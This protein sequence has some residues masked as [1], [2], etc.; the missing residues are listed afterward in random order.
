MMSLR[1]IL[2]RHYLL[3]ALGPLALAGIL[4]GAYF[5]FLSLNSTLDVESLRAGQ[6]AL[7]LED[8]LTRLSESLHGQQ[9]RNSIMD[10]PPKER[11]DVLRAFM[12]AH[13]LIRELMLVCPNGNEILHLSDY[14]P[15]HMDSKESWHG[16]PEF[17]IPMQS[18]EPFVSKVRIH[19]DSGAP[20]LTVSY[21]LVAPES[22][23]PRCVVALHLR[24][25]EL[26][27]VIAGYSLLPGETLYLVDDSGMIVVHPD[28]SLVLART[29]VSPGGFM[30]LASIP[31]SKRPCVRTMRPSYNFV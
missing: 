11:R 13:P 31:G 7:R 10:I 26:M 30:G 15:D 14:M 18:G 8:A 24:L 21:P 4:L 12:A 1:Q 23:K 22:G 17:E 9:L 25:S 5:M 2:R 3:L 27:E 29:V 16:R 19:P 28:T 6:T 20:G